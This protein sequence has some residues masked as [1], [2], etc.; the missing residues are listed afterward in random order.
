LKQVKA[1]AERVR[2]R[3]RN[4]EG[5]ESIRGVFFVSRILANTNPLS[6]LTDINE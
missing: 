3:K 2:V 6:S 5:S 4:V 1:V